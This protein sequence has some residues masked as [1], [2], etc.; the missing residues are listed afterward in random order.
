M[1]IKP[2]HLKDLPPAVAADLAAIAAMKFQEDVESEAFA[3]VLA[4]QPLVKALQNA[5]CNTWRDAL[6]PSGW[7]SFDDQDDPLLIERIT[8]P[9]PEPLGR[10]RTATLDAATEA[11]LTT[12]AS[13][14]AALGRARGVTQRRAQQLVEG[15]IRRAERGDDLFLGG[16]GEVA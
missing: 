9:E 5:K 7:L 1:L 13:G 10:W 14:T 2:H 4:G 15:H 11:L 6:R 8:S 16:E 3:N 12:L